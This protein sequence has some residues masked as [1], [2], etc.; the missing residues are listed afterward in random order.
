MLERSG[1]GAFDFELHEGSN[2]RIQWH[3]FERNRL[4]V[5]VQSWEIPPG[6]AEGMHAHD[7]DEPLE[8]LYLVVAGEATMRVAEQTYELG[9][10][11]SVLAPVGVDHDVRNTGSEPLK[12]VVVWG[13]PGEADFSEFGTAKAARAARTDG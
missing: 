13:A 6:G 8:E 10:G 9:P 3:F 1:A 7:E 4:P 5:A 2:T 12:M 11:D